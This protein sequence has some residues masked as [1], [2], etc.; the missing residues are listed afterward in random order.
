MTWMQ[1]SNLRIYVTFLGK[2][3]LIAGVKGDVLRAT[4][5]LLLSATRQR[6]A[7]CVADNAGAILLDDWAELD[8]QF[9]A[10]I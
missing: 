8:R 9:D 10:T 7:W 1:A 3:D 5:R 2:I 4:G 6:C